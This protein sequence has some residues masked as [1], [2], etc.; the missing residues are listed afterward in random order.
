MPEMK[1]LHKVLFP[2]IT[3]DEDYQSSLPLE[4][5]SVQVHVSGPLASVVVTQ[6]FGNPITETAEMEYLFPLPENAAIT[7]FDL[8]VGKR[9]VEGKLEELEAARRAYETARE[10]GKRAGLFEQR[11]PNLFAVQLTNVAVGETIQ[12]TMHYQ[13]RLRFDD[14][15]YEFVF[16]MGITPKYDSPAHPDEGKGVQAPIANT[17][18]PVGPVTIQLSV[19]A[20]VAL[21]GEPVSPSH[22]IEVTQMDERRFQAAVAGEQIPDHDF[23]LRWP[24]TGEGL[25]AAGWSSGSAGKEIFMA[26]LLPARLEE[27]PV[28]EPREFIF[29]L[30]RSGSMSGEP[31]RQ[32]RNALQACL[33]ALSGEDTF[34]LMLFDHVVEWYKPEPVRLTQSELEQADAYLSKVDGRGGTEIVTAIEEALRVPTQGNRPRFV[35]FL[36]DGAVSAEA[37][38]LEQIRGK[39]G[40]ARLFTFGIG[41][42]VNRALLNRMAS[43]GRGRA[44]FLQLN[45]DIEGAII[46]FQDRVSFPMLSDLQMEWKNA[47]AWDVYPT[48]LPDLYAGQPLEIC[49]RLSRK[50][51]TAGLTVRGKRAG[52]EVVISLVLPEATQADPAVERLWARARIDDLIEQQLLE[53]AQAAK[54]RDEIISLALEYHLV[55]EWTA[56]AAVDTE[57]R[58]GGKPRMIR[59][60]QPLPQGL[61][62]GVFAPGQQFVRAAMSPMS[63]ALPSSPPASS[64]SGVLHSASALFSRALKSKRVEEFRDQSVAFQSQRLSAPL[65]EVTQPDGSLENHE[66]LLRWLART[67]NA[68][69]SWGEDGEQTA[70]ALLAFIRAGNTS[71]SGS[72]RQVMRKALRW[73]SDA[74]LDRKN[75]FLRCRVLEELAQKT[76]DKKDRS[77]ADACRQ[78]LPA[79]ESVFEKACMRQAAQPPDAIQSLEDL[80]LAVLLGHVLPISPKLLKGDQADLA[81]TWAA[82]LV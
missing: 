32:A 43:M 60:A 62:P 66:G 1:E 76:G 53:P 17:S 22:P 19:D 68:N 13:Q 45:E 47:S 2:L 40:S 41:P 79:A 29:V 28:S 72:F 27:E 81:R 10:E 34:R 55:T 42:S 56:F 57:T 18:D 3:L 67:Q 51:G 24:V 64:G 6:R 78:S 48:R 71:R 9:R 70:A 30:D 49:G 46:R 77:Q 14:E 20:G 52:K 54:I 31:I 12:A 73:L 4:H 7:G 21:A 5:T 44:E 69:G 23:V 26:T 25:K 35:V 58:Q 50:Q 61:A 16:P 74:N 59:I 39:I 36:T 75:A 82:A 15:S 33:R 63:G 37:R 11:R 8:Q 65:P 38:A 80:R